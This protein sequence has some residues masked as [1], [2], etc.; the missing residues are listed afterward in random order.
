VILVAVQ[1]LERRAHPEHRR[2]ARLALDEL[3]LRADVLDAHAD[4]HPQGAHVIERPQVEGHG[5]L[6]ELGEPELHQ[7][8]V[9]ADGELVGQRARVGEPKVE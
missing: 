6:L 2:D 1:D 3:H 5:A 8:G 9:H 4:L 7:V